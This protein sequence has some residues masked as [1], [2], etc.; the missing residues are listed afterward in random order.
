MMRLEVCGL[1]L[2]APGGETLIDDLDLA[3]HC[4]TVT[5]LMGPS[6]SGKSSVLGWLTGTLAPG[7]QAR[8]QLTLDGR[9]LLT[10]PTERRRIGLMLQSDFLFPHMTVEENLLFG[11]RGGT[12]RARRERVTANLAD[13]G[14]DGLGPRDPATLSGGQRARVSLLRTLLS[15]P[16]VLLLDEPFS[17]LDAARREQIRAFT[18]QRASTLPV[19][20]VTHDVADIPAGARVI[21]IGAGGRAVTNAGDRPALDAG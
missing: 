9:S 13:A 2:R 19:L 11:L 3:L 6:G 18:W 7:F 20:L 16:A 17:R 4:G 21:E 10:V 5:V 15:D 1:T 8:G 12:R 14:L